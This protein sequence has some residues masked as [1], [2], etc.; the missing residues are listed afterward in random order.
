VKPIDA[1]IFDL[2]GTLVPKWSGREAR[3]NN[4]AIAECVGADPEA[5]QAAW[6]STFHDREQGRHPTVGHAI[7]H[8]LPRL[9]G[10][11]DSERLAEIDAMRR[12]LHE[13]RI[14]ARDDVDDTLREIKRRGVALGLLSNVSPPGSEVFR[15]LQMSRHFA[16]LVFSCEEGMEK[17]DPAI[18]ERVLAEMGMKPERCLYVGDGGSRELTAAREVGMHPVLIRVDHE[19]E[20][21]G[22]DEDAAEWTGPTIRSIREVLGFLK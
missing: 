19:I 12:H 11:A 10:E 13:R 1:V 6:D 15:R 16:A 4:A 20:A 7:R 9:G 22:W 8:I 3:A 17:P 18:Y 21:E 5:F 2:F 14:V